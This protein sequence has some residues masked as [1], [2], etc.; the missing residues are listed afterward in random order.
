M[1]KQH[2]AVSTHDIYVHVQR[3]EK[4]RI[5]PEHEEKFFDR[6]RWQ[7]SVRRV[8]L[9]LVRKGEIKRIRRDRYVSKKLPE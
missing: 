2:S 3:D 9:E 1:K 8:I 5:L 4:I 6:P 7:H